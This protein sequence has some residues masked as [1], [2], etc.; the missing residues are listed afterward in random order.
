MPATASVF[1]IPTSFDFES[2]IMPVI[3][4]G[5]AVIPQIKKEIIPIIKD[6]IPSE[7]PGFSLLC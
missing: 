3:I 7:A 1:F 6:A 4:E 5:I 2:P